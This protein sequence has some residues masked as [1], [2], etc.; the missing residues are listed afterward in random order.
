MKTVRDYARRRGK[1]NR[2][3]ER[4]AQAN[5]RKRLGNG[6]TLIGASDGLSIALL[7]PD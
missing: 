4:E 5:N 1:A 2:M 6:V 7:Q 3:P